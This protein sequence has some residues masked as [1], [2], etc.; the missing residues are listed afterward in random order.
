MK[1]YVLTVSK[2]FP[3]THKRKG[4]PTYFAEKIFKEKCSEDV[5]VKIREEFGPDLIPKKHTI[6]ANY[7]LWK[8][9]I[10]EVNEGKAIISLRQWSGNPYNSPQIEVMQFGVE[11]IGYQR[12]MIDGIYRFRID[13]SERR[14]DTEELAKNDGLSD[15]DFKE[16]FKNYDLE[17][18][19]IIHFTKFR[20]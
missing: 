4:E 15:S 14:C 1:T 13:G 12:I 2:T 19:I 5:K 7:D 6:R 18:M 17:P 16:W 9:R 8:K 20:Y 3:V 10:D 11:E